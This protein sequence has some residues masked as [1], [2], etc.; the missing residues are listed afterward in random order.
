MAGLAAARAR[1]RVGGRKPALN[2]KKREVALALYR[3][4]SVSIDEIC[5]TLGVSRTTF[6]R[7]LPE[8]EATR[9]DG[10]QSFPEP[11][12]NLSTMPVPPTETHRPVDTEAGREIDF[13]P[14]S[15]MQPT[16]AMQRLNAARVLVELDQTEWQRR[17]FE[18]QEARRQFGDILPAFS[19]TVE[20]MEWAH[21]EVENAPKHR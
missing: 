6:Y 12:V 7:S 21:R 5:R 1:G 8:R 10:P 4:K 16:L 20:L 15:I 3:D 18:F 19:S 17:T 11:S 14:P 13:T 2:A 9:I